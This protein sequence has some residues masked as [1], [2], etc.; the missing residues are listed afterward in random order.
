MDK[1]WKAALVFLCIFL[2]GGVAGAFVG[3]RVACL[4]EKGRP[5]PFAD[6][7]PFP[8][9]PIDDWSKRKQKEFSTRL[10]LTPAQQTKTEVLFQEAQSELRQ[11]REHSFQQ[12]TEITSRLEAQIMDL[13]SPEQRPKFTQLIKEREERQKKAAAERAAA[14]GR[15]ERPSRP[16]EPPPGLPPGEPSP[17]GPPPPGAPFDKALSSPSAPAAGSAQAAATAVPPKTP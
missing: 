7:P 5:A 1:N 3:M 10:E 17:E 2:A 4:K 15:Y 14:G 13:L 11:V 8:R 12:A 9:R 6:G 16:S